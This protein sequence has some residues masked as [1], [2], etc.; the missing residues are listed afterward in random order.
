MKIPWYLIQRHLVLILLLVMPGVGRAQFT[1]TNINGAITITGYTGTGGAITIPATLDGLPVTAIG[2]APSGPLTPEQQALLI[3]AERQSLQAGSPVNATAASTVTS[4]TIDNGLL[5]INS[6]AFYNWTALGRVSIPASVTN[7]ELTAFL[8]CPNLTNL[9]VAAGNRHYSSG[10][11]VLFDKQQKTLLV[12]P[13]GRTGSYSI[14]ATVTGLGSQAFGG[15]SG[16]TGVVIPQG[17]TNIPSGTFY[18]CTNLAT[19]AV[20]ARNPDYGSVNGVLYNHGQTTLL[21]FPGAWAGNF[22]VPPGVTTIGADAFEGCAGLTGIALPPSLTSLGNDAFAN[23]AGLTNVVIPNRVTSLGVGAFQGCQGLVAVTL[24]QSVTSLGGD[25]FSGCNR[26]AAIN[27]PDSLTSIG[28][29]A[30]QLCY[31]LDGITI[32]NGVVSIAASAFSDTGLTNVVLGSGVSVLAD[33]VFANDGS[34]TNVTLT[35]RVTSIGQGVFEECSGLTTFTIPDSV[36]NIGSSAFAGTS[37]TRI[38]IPTNVISI[39]ISPFG[40]PY[41][42][43]GLYGIPAPGIPAPLNP[44]PIIPI[45]VNPVPIIPP[46]V[47]ASPLISASVVASSVVPHASGSPTLQAINVAPG[48]PAYASVN[49]VL[50]TRD[51]ATLIEYPYGLGG[52]YVIPAGVTDI[53][54]NAFAGASQLTGIT[55]P[56]GVTGIGDNAFEQCSELGSVSLPDSVTSLGNDVFGQCAALTNAV[57]GQG[58]TSLGTALFQNCNTLVGVTLG[59]QVASIGITAFTGCTDLAGLALPAG[60][61]SIG[62]D[63]FMGSGLTNVVIPGSVT[64]IGVL[65][66]ANCNRLTAITVAAG[67]LDYS[68]AGGSLFDR[69]QTTLLQCPGA[70]TGVYTIPAAATTIATAAFQSCATLNGVTVPAGVTNLGSDVFWYC[71]DL[72]NVFFAGNAPASTGA[73][74]ED[75][76]N[77]VTYEPGTSGWT[78]MFGG[79]PA[80]ALG[81]PTGALRV[82]IEPADFLLD[83]DADWEVD[84]GISHQGN[85]TVNGLTVGNHT[86]T[87]SS[88]PGW[89]NPASQTVWVTA[90]VTNQVTGTYV[91][92]N[93]ITPISQ[94][95]YTTDNGGITITSYIGSDEFVTIPDEINGLPVT[96]IGASAFPNNS[97]L[98]GVSIPKSVTSIGDYAFCA[99]VNLTSV[100]IPT[101]VT[102]IGNFVFI[103][104]GLTN[105][106]MGDSVT[107]IGHAAFASCTNLTGITLPDSVI[108]IG[109]YAFSGSGLTHMAIPNSV[110][111]LGDY[112]FAQCSDL[113]SVTLGDGLTSL[114]NDVFEFCTSLTKLTIPPSITSIQTAAF[115]GCTNLAGIYFL[116]NAPDLGIGVF[117][118]DSTTLYYPP[119]TTGWPALSGNYDILPWYPPT[120]ALQVTIQPPAAVADG[121]QWQVDGGAW[122]SS[123]VTVSNI[124]TGSH[125]VS[126]NPISGWTPPAGITLLVNSNVTST[127]SGTYLQLPGAVQVII[128]PPAA[129]SAGAEW[130]VNGGAWQK[131][132]AIVGLTLATTQATVAF[133]TLPGWTSPAG[134]T[135]A[136]SAGQTNVLTVNWV[137]DLRPKVTINNLAAGQQV[138]SA[139]YTV[140]GTASDNAGVASVWYQLNNGAWTVA[141][142]PNNW[143]N[144]SAT[145]PLQ[146]G[147]NTLRTSAVDTAGRGTIYVADSQNNV[148][149][150]IL[151]GAVVVTFAGS[152]NHAT[153]FADGPATTALFNDPAG[154]AVDQAG[155]VYVADTGNNCIRKI[156]PAGGVTT[157]A[158]DTNAQTAGY[159]DGPGG[160]ARFNTPTSLAVD[161]DDNVY[162]A[163]DYNGLI[164]KITPGGQVSTIAGDTYDLTNG[165]YNLGAALGYA[166]GPGNAAKFYSPYGIALGSTGELYVSDLGNNLIRQISPGGVVTTL[167][168]DTYDLTNGGYNAPAAAGY[169][170]GAGSAAKF[171]APLG[172]AVDLFGNILVA[173]RAN[174]LVR[175]ISP[176][177]VVSTL[178]GDIYDL[179]NNPAGGNAGY[180]DGAAGTAQFNYPSDVGMDSY[181]NVLVADSGNSLIREISPAGSVTTLAGD[182]YDLTN[183]F[184]GYYLGGYLDGV[185]TAAEFNQA[186]GLV[187]DN[188][189]AN[190]S[191]VSTVTFDYVPS[192][193]LVVQVAG[194]GTVSPDYNKVELA[195]GGNYH[196]TATAQRG[197]GFVFTNWT[198]LNIFTAV[199]SALNE[200]GQPEIVGTNTIIS[201]GAVATNGPTLSF[202]MTA[203]VTLIS[204]PG[205]ETISESTG[206]QANF[207]D[208]E[209]PVL[210]INSPTPNEFATNF[211]FLVQGTASDNAAVASVWYQFNGGGWSTANGTNLW[212]VP[213]TL[214]PGTNTIQAYAVDTSGN[215]SATNTVNFVFEFKLPFYLIINGQGTVTPNYRGQ[216][217]QAGENYTITAIPAKGFAF[218]NWYAVSLI[219][220]LETAQPRTV[221]PDPT[222]IIPSDPPFYLTNSPTLKFTMGG[223]LAYIA[224]FVDIAP[225]VV[226]ITA[227]KPNERVS[228]TVFTVTGTARDN[229]G[230][231]GVYY[232]LNGAGW[233]SAS[234]G[235]GYTNWFTPALPLLSAT[236]NLLQVYAMDTSSNVS[237]T[238]T[239]EFDNLQQDPAPDSLVNTLANGTSFTNTGF[240]FHFGTNTFSLVPYISGQNPSVG[241]YTYAKLTPTNGQLTFASTAPPAAVGGP[242]TVD[243]AFTARDTGTYSNE[244]SGD[245]GTISFSPAYP[246]IPD[247][248]SGKTMRLFSSNG[249][250]ATLN[251]ASGT[252]GFTNT[253]G[254][255][256]A[257]DYA[258]SPVSPI[259]GLLTW[260]DALQGTNYLVLLSDYTNVGGFYASAYDAAGNVTGIDSGIYA[261]PTRAPSAPASLTGTEAQTHGDDGSESLIGF[262]TGT[263][264]QYGYV[265]PPT[266]STGTYGYVKN[267]PAGARLSLTETGP[268]GS[269]NA[270]QSFQLNFVTPQCGWFTN[271]AEATSNVECLVFFPVAA[272]APAAVTGLTLDATNYT[273]RFIN[274]QFVPTV[275]VLTFSTRGRFTQVETAGADQA[276]STG[277]WQ[278]HVYSPVGAVFQ[279]KYT[280][281]GSLAGAINYLQATFYQSGSGLLNGTFFDNAGDPPVRSLAGFSLH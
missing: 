68:S 23:C 228:N 231:A 188:T 71:Y 210:H 170:D 143:T 37:L 103:E 44:I 209:K 146:P 280:S 199:E 25:A 43:P 165:G 92:V 255:G 119:W 234:T 54:T 254:E 27:L 138:T 72:T 200:F 115:Y 235:D 21:Q 113:A 116:G 48:N 145:L 164:R 67:N 219:Q 135:V 248:L 49:G 216:Q 101:N 257:A 174:N 134:Q 122:Q 214:T 79:V 41:N 236:Q 33:E 195:L 178:A 69:N 261:L 163:D 232:Q 124:I 162:V 263:Y 58:V 89:T 217:L 52:S 239:I 2:L 220:P 242:V 22:T 10:D 85:Q 24:G 30:F 267:S 182:T 181:G 75:D 244:N 197:S 198:V 259:S 155:N 26:L 96:A 153:G 12:Y 123:G 275:D 18:N 194:E 83:E 149:R 229:A 158:G 91:G 249:V 224:N 189:G 241:L 131:S 184:Y 166:D 270:E 137:D 204:V 185:G 70:A 42:G 157:L 139:A 278:Y 213:V 20:A 105:V 151:P 225:P 169:A 35:G 193:P 262:G 109:S 61:L 152:T 268:P 7:I 1:W 11:G 111:N 201:P 144:W 32:P 147:V 206:Y 211:N 171:S 180:A 167:A 104:C 114:G 154:T 98:K 13:S 65:A 9:T 233:Q 63:A 82:T 14:P 177:G 223:F 108:S 90:N 78:N 191:P 168:G 202:T 45:P 53:E 276:V 190:Y 207:L 230:V 222:P 179:T 40:S 161:G 148:I 6:L 183:I 129:A 205:I 51:L 66:F 107:N 55:I 159:A 226:T 121:A 39:G 252:L 97:F 16:L 251:F 76:N 140:T 74:F 266:S 272:L 93:Q 160:Q 221:I 81:A 277:T 273:E 28:L 80:A 187:V 60:L 8:D 110:T 133:N 274:N 218:T 47:I 269:T 245:T 99:S 117:F 73:Q 247:G 281:P 50:F 156:T 264:S 102:S 173:D 112:A 175:D 237:P 62:V 4:V 19:I 136:V 240:T 36:T 57:I 141:A 215:V 176:A 128:D 94:F 86:V 95:L 46:P 227:P 64:N 56:A 118:L 120:G 238:T 126:F 172:L 5:N 59:G 250:A 279:L 84:G 256:G 100:T 243:L 125:T 271:Q 132:G 192:A 208:V 265:S 29:A 142:T 17:L 34:L 212:S 106:T 38:T 88:V 203:P 130:R 3:E 258:F 31:A 150:E 186:M 87:F 260:G 253:A 246:L 77:T 15:C 127:A 196:M